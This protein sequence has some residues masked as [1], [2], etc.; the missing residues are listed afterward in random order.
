MPTL[1]EKMAEMSK[2]GDG[3]EAQFREKVMKATGTDPASMD[4]SVS[5]KVFYESA[6][7]FAKW[8][9]DAIK[10]AEQGAELEQAAV[11]P[12]EAMLK[13]N[14]QAEAA[15]AR[16]R[17]VAKKLIDAKTRA[18]DPMSVFSDAGD[19]ALAADKGASMR[20]VARS[21]GERPS[22]G[23]FVGAVGTA[24][25]ALVGAAKGTYKALEEDPWLPSRLAL[26]A[27][28]FQPR[29]TEQWLPTP[30]KGPVSTVRKE[31]IDKRMQM[32]PATRTWQAVK[33]AGQGMYALGKSVAGVT[34]LE[35]IQQ[36]GEGLGHG[37]T[38]DLAGTVGNFV[39][40]PIRTSL[41][42]PEGLPELI[43]PLARAGGSALRASKATK[44]SGRTGR[45]AGFAADVLDP[46][47]P[48][49]A[50]EQNRVEINELARESFDRYKE[51]LEM[52]NAERVASGTAQKYL[53]ETD[54]LIRARA[55][56][57]S[58]PETTGAK[59]GRAIRRAGTGA[60]LLGEA[61]G[62][63]PASFA[64]MAGI[65]AAL[66]PLTSAFAKTFVPDE[67]RADRRQRFIDASAMPTIDSE[68]HVREVTENP[69]RL[70]SGAVGGGRG[71]AQNIARN[72]DSTRM[73]SDVEPVHFTDKIL[74]ADSA[75]GSFQSPEGTVGRHLS[76]DKMRREELSV[77]HASNFK[78]N[79]LRRHAYDLSEDMRTDMGEDA[80]HYYALSRKYVAER[81]RA[82]KLWADSVDLDVKTRE[83]IAAD[84]QAY[85]R[86]QLS[87]DAMAAREAYKEAKVRASVLD[88]I[89]V[90]KRPHVV[91]ALEDARY[92]AAR[93][94]VKIANLEVSEPSAKEAIIL[95][96]QV[97]QS[98]RVL[99]ATELLESARDVPDHWA[100]GETGARAKHLGVTPR[101]LLRMVLD[102]D[103][104]EL[105]KMKSKIKDYDAYMDARE[106]YKTANRHF[107][108]VKK[109]HGAVV[110]RASKAA[111]KLYDAEI[112]ARAKRA[113]VKENNALLKG[114]S[115]ER[116][117]EIERA[118][119]EMKRT[120][121]QIQEMLLEG[122]KIEAAQTG[123]LQKIQTHEMGKTVVDLLAESASETRKS[124]A[125]EKAANAFPETEA[126]LEK[127]T[128]ENQPRG[129]IEP[130]K[131]G[132]KITDPVTK[133]ARIVTD[134]KD[135][136]VIE[137]I[138]RIVR[139]ADPQS[140]LGDANYLNQM[141][142]NTWSKNIL[143]ASFSARAR[144][145]VSK[146]IAAE[147]MSA[148][149]TSP[150][151][152]LKGNKKGAFHLDK[153]KT[154]LGVDPDSPILRSRKKTERIIRQRIERLISEESAAALMSGSPADVRIAI[155]TESGMRVMSM[156][157]ITS[158]M[159]KKMDETDPKRAQDIRA[160]SI[161]GILETIKSHVI[162]DE[163][164]SAM[165]REAMRTMSLGVDT[166]NQAGHAAA[167]HRTLVSSEAKPN[168]LLFDPSYVTKKS[169]N[170]ADVAEWYRDATNNPNMT[171]AGAMERFRAGQ[172]YFEDNFVKA[173]DTVETAI[174][175]GIRKQGGTVPDNLPIFVQK[176][177][178]ESVGTHLRHIKAVDEARGLVMDAGGFAKV[179]YLVGTTATQVAN[180]FSNV[181]AISIA[182][183]DSPVKVVANITQ[184]YG[185]LADY[186][187]GRL[188]GF[189][190]A[191]VRAIMS[192]GIA[193]SSMLSEKFA[194]ATALDTSRGAKGLLLNAYQIRK[195]LYKQGDSGPKLATTFRAFDDIYTMFNEVEPGRTMQLPTG[196]GAYVTLVKNANG[197][198]SINGGKTF[199]AP[200]S[201][202]VMNQVARTSA[203]FAG[204]VMFNFNDLPGFV[205]KSVGNKQV[206]MSIFNP[207]L[208]WSHK[209][210]ELPGKPGIMSNVLGYNP[211]HGVITDSPA[212]QRSKS[213]AFAKLAMK[214]LA[215]GQSM[216]G[217]GKIYDDKGIGQARSWPGTTAMTLASPTSDGVRAMEMT[218]LSS[219]H[220]SVI[221]D[222][223][224]RLMLSG[225]N[226]AY[227][228]IANKTAEDYKDML[229]NGSETQKNAARLYFMS[230]SGDLASAKT[231]A[232]YFG[233]TGTI[234]RA[235]MKAIDTGTG[236]PQAMRSTMRMMVGGD[237]TTLTEA[238]IEITMPNTD[239]TS[240]KFYPSLKRKEAFA[241]WFIGNFFRFGM[242]E[243]PLKGNRGVMATIDR[244]VRSVQDHWIKPFEKDLAVARSRGDVEAM[245]SLKET[246]KA[247]ESVLR[248]TE[249]LYRKSAQEALRGVRSSR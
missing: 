48:V 208:S 27:V 162:S 32:T 146:T 221:A 145:Y 229:R 206:M 63:S 201:P 60:I 227:T 233:I 202:E 130:Q 177:Y 61:A 103:I 59:V 186:E 169:S 56:T 53:D 94:R 159:M 188:T 210:S 25:T 142:G 72:A 76:L 38:Y 165:G 223:A 40:D 230:K 205:K 166:P 238:A 108:D 49:K 89:K 144:G 85:R 217:A 105:E 10:T 147:I 54:S 36:T 88:Q 39:A 157:E 78:A 225:V 9:A 242:R 196:K 6:I 46:Q 35:T 181:M 247:S 138:A 176:G 246:I 68:M 132:E 47:K 170:P 113:A 18:R 29:Y 180:M 106:A 79:A 239:I 58:A 194:A 87:S 22:E 143:A 3:S 21:E 57:L 126:K 107:D 179:M 12:I 140:P 134:P 13:S 183:G 69:Q 51:I 123:R 152:R 141:F 44:V 231:L 243:I 20:S 228:M 109:Q 171:D 232:G 240:R 187:A 164:H 33:E 215:L 160:E 4:Q 17:D 95:E 204:D 203:Q 16:R 133:Q 125:A 70:A 192:T 156:A 93:A 74:Q 199:H 24:G 121:A 185:K 151:H 124:K 137:D 249:K 2:R 73:V 168:I 116:R 200:D 161:N 96:R 84:P 150:W 234:L 82:R 62:G 64:T 207:Y 101:K 34:D 219:V 80:P 30:E 182:T 167:S 104:I 5:Y 66:P 110:E 112:D 42:L 55:K 1:G 220:F 178:N 127:V 67:V 173:D 31:K 163:T 45:A 86:A 98:R 115:K 235:Q 122:A 222:A 15:E 120:E 149:P 212:L 19:I 117:A 153:V 148:F 237:I 190:E 100:G 236:I 195:E 224:L 114:L 155:P 226:G 23:P 191:K 77:Q 91:K 28:G 131:L 92:A 118:G 26:R 43:M 135:V 14:P 99:E 245:K 102:S 129:P 218:D 41:A 214:R 198:I 50:F 11:A 174:K 136:G 81:D 197:E 8:R 154:W 71:M 37:V 244:R 172:K 7:K 97:E 83:A 184:A 213:K 248:S 211:A 193:D 119:R 111:N 139:E 52:E 65:S 175:A 189:E 158:K 90:E 75:T 209:A 216:R 128:G 241:G